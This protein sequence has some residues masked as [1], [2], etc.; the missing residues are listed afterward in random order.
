MQRLLDDAGKISGIEYDIS[1][2]ADVTQAIHVMQESM[3]IAGTTAKEAS[4]TISG[5]VSSMKSAWE[6]LLVGVADGSQDLNGLIKNFTDS[7]GIVAQ[8]IMPDASQALLGV[9]GLIG[10]LLPLVMQQIPTLANEIL[11][12]LLES[13]TMISSTFINGLIDGMFSGEI[14][15][16][17]II[18]MLIE[19]FSTIGADMF[20]LGISI[21]DNLLS[22]FNSNAETIMQSIGYLMDNIIETILVFGP[23]MLQNGINLIIQLALGLSQGIP[24]MIPKIIDIV[25]MIVI[26]L[27][28]NAPMLV[29]AALQLIIGL[30]TGLIQALPQLIEMLPEIVI[31]IVQALIIAAPLSFGCSY[32]IN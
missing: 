16:S 21:I 2:F 30:A 27:I 26:T 17:G 22:G 5:S 8:N 18:T 6:N 20:M 15:L 14:D 23:E 32:W 4:T 31:A 13:A 1:S 29:Q 3:G 19:A 10:T 28:Q 12:Q 9:S 24:Q 7:V 25:M 11:P